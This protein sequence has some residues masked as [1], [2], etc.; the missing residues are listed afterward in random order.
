MREKA[1]VRTSQ[2]PIKGSDKFLLWLIQ[3]PPNLTSPPPP[4]QTIITGPLWEYF[5]LHYFNHCVYWWPE[6]IYNCQRFETPKH[7]RLRVASAER[8]HFSV[9]ILF[10]GHLIDKDSFDS[11]YSYKYLSCFYSENLKQDDGSL[12]RTSDRAHWLVLPSN[13]FS[14][15]SA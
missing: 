8:K 12:L 6:D 11:S 13:L 7:F 9:Y 4:P 2:S 15:L 1:T 10:W 14:S 5:S 3:N